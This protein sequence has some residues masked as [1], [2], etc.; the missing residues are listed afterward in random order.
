MSLRELMEEA[1]LLA[2][3]AA[4][5]FTEAAALLYL[6]WHDSFGAPS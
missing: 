2:V 4:L 5:S 3:A 1:V 6:W